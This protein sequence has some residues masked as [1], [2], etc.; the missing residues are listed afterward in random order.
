MYRV[1]IAMR[2]TEPTS[3]YS[4]SVV[5]LRREIDTDGRTDVRVHID[6]ERSPIHPCAIA[7]FCLQHLR[8]FARPVP[9]IAPCAPAVI[10]EGA[11]GGFEVVP[12]VDTG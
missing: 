1:R 5:G 10:E 12:L 4:Y 7:L 3:S 6:L 8:L 2:T 11:M 9:E